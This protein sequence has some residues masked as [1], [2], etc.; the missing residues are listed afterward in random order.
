VFGDGLVTSKGGIFIGTIYHH[1]PKVS[2]CCTRA[3]RQCI[4]V[5]FSSG[6]FIRALRP[7]RT[8]TFKVLVC[9]LLDMEA[10]PE[11]LCPRPTAC[12]LEGNAK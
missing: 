11:L 2:L 9:C 12:L 1:C 7:G 4:H 10:V 8:V 3:P 5:S 6:A